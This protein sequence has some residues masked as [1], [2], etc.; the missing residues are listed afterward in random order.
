[1]YC[2]TNDAGLAEAWPKCIQDAAGAKIEKLRK[3]NPSNVTGLTKDMYTGRCEW[4]DYE[5]LKK[6]LRK[7]GA[8]RLGEA[9]TKG[10]WAIVMCSLATGVV[11]Y[12]V[13]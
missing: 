2:Y 1:M 11:L 5:A 8:I 6:G 13:M 10:F 9:W 12:Q 3:T 4:I 7:S